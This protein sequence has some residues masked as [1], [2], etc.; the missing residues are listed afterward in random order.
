MICQRCEALT[1]YVFPAPLPISSAFIHHKSYFPSVF[2]FFYIT[3]LFIVFFV[4]QYIKW[5]R[6]ECSKSFFQKKIFKSNIAF[7]CVLS[8][9][10]QREEGRGD[11][12]HDF[13]LPLFFPSFD[14]LCFSPFSMHL[15]SSFILWNYSY[16]FVLNKR[17]SER[18]S[19]RVRSWVEFELYTLCSIGEIRK[20]KKTIVRAFIWLCAAR[21]LHLMISD[22]TFSLCLSISTFS[23][24]ADHHEQ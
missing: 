9:S 3:L 12:M 14:T 1:F 4:L 7:N 2:C 6:K 24:S 15:S 23:I 8:R 19:E 13:F 21:L 18:W 10:A 22:I 5:Y 16:S 20:G 11:K 17:W